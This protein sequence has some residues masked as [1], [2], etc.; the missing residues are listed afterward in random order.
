MTDVEPAQDFAGAPDG[1]ERLWVPHR[2]A[3]VNGPH[4]DDTSG[5]PDSAQACP[6][7]EAP[8]KSDEDALIV[9]RGELVYALLNLFPYNS[10][11]ILVCPYRHIADYTELT[12]EETVEFSQFTQHAMRALREARHPQGFNLGINQGAV[13]GA[14]IAAHLHQHVI[15][16]WIGDSNFFPIVAQTRALPE[17]LSDTRASI[18]GAWE[19]V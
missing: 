17:L 3:Y 18:A 2:L 10:G 8:H 5:A 7:C 13:A 4:N 9:A 19:S 14:G 11:H 1:Y 15:P 12:P 16:R 6:F